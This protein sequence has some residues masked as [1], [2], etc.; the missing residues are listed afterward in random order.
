MSIA[1]FA[2]EVAVILN[3]FATNVAHHSTTSAPHFVASIFLYKFF[4]TIPT[5]SG[6]DKQGIRK[7]KIT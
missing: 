4:P 6:I 3:R 2:I 7:T 1:S 5:G